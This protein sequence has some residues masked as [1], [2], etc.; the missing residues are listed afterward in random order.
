MYALGHGLKETE[1]ALILGAQ[2][3]LL[4]AHLPDIHT[5]NIRTQ[6]TGT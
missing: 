1:A 3:T 6:P 5:I 4:W 2:Q